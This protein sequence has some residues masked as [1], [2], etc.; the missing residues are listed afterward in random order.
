M[1]SLQEW[2]VGQEKKLHLYPLLPTPAFSQAPQLGRG[3]VSR[4]RP[5]TLVITFNP[6][7]PGPWYSIPIA[8]QLYGLHCWA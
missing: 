7:W 8:E 2:A 3:K 5:L 4:Q 6:S 1:S